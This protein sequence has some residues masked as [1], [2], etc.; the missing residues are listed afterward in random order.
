[1][2]RS[3]ET[4]LQRAQRENLGHALF[5]VARLLDEIAQRELNA[6]AGEVIARPALMRLLPFLDF[7]GV[8]PSDLARR[9]DV[10]KQAIHQALAELESRGLVEFTDDPH[11][12]RAR[13]VRL[14]RQGGH[15]YKH[16]LS[17][18]DRLTDLLKVEVGSPTLAELQSALLIMWPVLERWKEQGLPKR[19]AHARDPRAPAPKR[20]PKQRP[21]ARD[22]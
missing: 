22:N 8:R 20:R 1:M 11:D 18:L 17:V 9:V 10:S 14:T 4:E 5:T 6:A 2:Q 16:G 13:L 15:A 7:E 19:T 12:G 21:L 3:Q